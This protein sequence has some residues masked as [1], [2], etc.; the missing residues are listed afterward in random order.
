MVLPTAVTATLAVNE[1]P[2]GAV[3]VAVAVNVRIVPPVTVAVAMAV[4]VVAGV[5]TG[6]LLWK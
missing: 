3:A 6:S 5:E 2:S 4:A 1:R